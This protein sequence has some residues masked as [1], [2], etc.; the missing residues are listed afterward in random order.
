MKS[1][2][3]LMN[4]VSPSE[5][6]L[7]KIIVNYVGEKLNPENDEITVEN[8]IDIFSQEFPEFLLSLAEENWV[9]GY[10]QA[11]KDVEYFEKKKNAQVQELN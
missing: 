5:S 8:I 4:S 1:K 10:T 2:N 6:E 11:L 9:N 3:I 7:K